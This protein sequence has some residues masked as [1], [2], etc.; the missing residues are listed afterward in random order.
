MN[1]VFLG[2][3]YS[4]DQIETLLREKNVNSRRLS[5][6]ELLEETS[7]LIAGQKVVGWFQ[8][9]ME[10][11]PRA[12]GNRS[13]IADARNPKNQSVVNL[14][15][16]FRESFRPFAPAVLEERMPEYFDF[17]RPAPV[18]L[19]VASV[20]PDKRVIPAVTRL[21]GSARLQ[22]I[23]RE[24]NALFYDLISEFD[25]QTDCPIII[26]TSFNVRG[27]PI[28]RTPR[29]ALRCFMSTEMD[30]LVMGSFII[31]KK[32]LGAYR[33]EL[34]EEEFELD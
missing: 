4:D 3:E 17:D 18:M 20:R 28:V 25:F 34:L 19:F 11:G 9:R 27:E 13:I 1:V 21:D 12:L 33:E 29:E 16:K 32:D 22:T 30:C 8:G 24:Q 15:I 2:Q 7:R 10:F 6:R 14:R 31:D 5:R 26:T 23:S